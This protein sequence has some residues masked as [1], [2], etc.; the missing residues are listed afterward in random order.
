[1]DALNYRDDTQ[2][3]ADFQCVCESRGQLA[4]GVDRGESCF[5]LPDQERHSHMESIMPAVPLWEGPSH[6]TKHMNDSL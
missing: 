4:N 3:Q 6:M 2:T 1:M 5:D